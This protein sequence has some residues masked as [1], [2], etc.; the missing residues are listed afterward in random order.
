MQIAELAKVP[1]SEEMLDHGQHFARIR[2]KLKTDI[3]YYNTMCRRRAERKKASLQNKPRVIEED[4]FYKRIAVTHSKGAFYQLSK[5][6]LP[7]YV[8]DSLL[9]VKRQS[10]ALQYPNRIYE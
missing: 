9:G 4:D 10:S 3:H 7:R 6:N 8:P 1:F 5:I 2:K